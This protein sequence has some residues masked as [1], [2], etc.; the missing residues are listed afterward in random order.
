M[1]T[2]STSSSTNSTLPT[3]NPTPIPPPTQTIPDPILTTYIPLAGLLVAPA[4]AS[5]P[6]R[7]LDLYTLGLASVFTLSGYQLYTVH[8]SRRRR[9]PQA[10]AAS[11]AQPR[12]EIPRGEMGKQDQ[13]PEVEEE[14]GGVV[15]MA[16]RLWYGDETAG[17]E[18]RRAEEERRKIE[19]GEGLW[20]II[21][22]RTREA[23]GGKRNGDEEEEGE[24]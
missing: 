3:T 13:K 8:Y 5:I 20:G 23:F 2:P 6:P 12:R 18:R 22:E 9:I 14:E 1:S 19:E 15:G 16:R 7:K 11:T 24:E 10:V 17:W 4:L 21:S